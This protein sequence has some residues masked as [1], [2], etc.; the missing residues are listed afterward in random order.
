MRVVYQW[1][2]L[3]EACEHAIEASGGAGILLDRFIVGLEMEVD[4]ASDGIDHLVG[5]MEHLEAAGVHSGDSI[6]RFPT[7]RA[8]EQARARAFEYSTAIA[9]ELSYVGLMNF[10]FVWDGKTLY[11]LEANPRASRSTYRP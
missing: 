4:M 9:R 10:Q 2:D 5:I 6:A 11:C 1:R 3:A 7:R 8:P